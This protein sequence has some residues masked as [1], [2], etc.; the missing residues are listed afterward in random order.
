MAVCIIP[1]VAVEFTDPA[2]MLATFVY[3]TMVC[4]E[5]LVTILA[6]GVV[7]CSRMA[8]VVL[9]FRIGRATALWM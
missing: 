3:L 5:L 6:F 8:L 7:G 9:R 1:M 2:R 4:M